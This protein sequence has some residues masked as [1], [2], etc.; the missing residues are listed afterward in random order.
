M[1]KEPV[2]DDLKQIIQ[3]DPRYAPEAYQF[4]RE[5]LE[6]TNKKLENGKRKPARHV[7]GEQLLEGI[8]RFALQE[9]G[10]MAKTVFNTWG[11][12]RCED[13]WYIIS[14]LVG[15]GILGCAPEDSIHDF[16]GGYDFDIAFRQPFKPA[17]FSGKE[18][19]T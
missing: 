1:K 15:K 12:F 19:S 10:P 14:N 4:L 18:R 6:F 3:A 16:E 9:Y 17:P 11:I 5:A 8:R 7:S 2:F 13:F